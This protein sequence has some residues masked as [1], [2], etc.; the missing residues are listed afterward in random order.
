MHFAAGEIKMAE[1]KTYIQNLTLSKF[2][3]TNRIILHRASGKSLSRFHA[4]SQSIAAWRVVRNMHFAEGEIK[5]AEV[6]TYIQNLTLSKFQPTNRII[7]HRASC[8]SLS[9][10]HAS[11][12]SIA[13]WR[14]V[15]KRNLPKA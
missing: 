3:P 9:R 10:F 1:V 14:V 12:Q 8:K 15:W 6:K 2:Q 13:A 5:M 11:S 4:T 7:L